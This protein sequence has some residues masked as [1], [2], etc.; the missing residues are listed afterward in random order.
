MK[1]PLKVPTKLVSKSQFN[2][3]QRVW[4]DILKLA[5]FVDIEKGRD[6][7]L[8]DAST[9]RGASDGGHGME[10]CQVPMTSNCL[11]PGM[12]DYSSPGYFRA[13][14]LETHEGF[15]DA[16]QARM[17][18]VLSRAAH[19]LP[20]ESGLRDLLVDVTTTGEIDQAAKRHGL[21]RET[22]RIKVRRLCE[23]VGIDYANLLA[24]AR[25]RR[26]EPQT[27]AAPVRRLSRREIK[28]LQYSPPKR[29]GASSGR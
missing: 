14:E 21:N 8:M 15:A 24:S 19:D 29:I 23:A 20:V 3:L 9:F 2:E 18:A 17:W 26:P 16:P 12:E 10:V 28:R 13:S 22:V 27:Q 5:D 1:R 11:R 4:D 25:P 7:N 6:L